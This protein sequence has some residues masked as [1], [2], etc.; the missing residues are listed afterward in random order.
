MSK[1]KKSP[2]PTYTLKTPKSMKQKKPTTYT[3]LKKEKK[4]STTKSLRL[5]KAS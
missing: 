3:T 4:C 1:A 5:K 2:Y